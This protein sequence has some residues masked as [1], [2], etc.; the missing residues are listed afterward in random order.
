METS[1]ITLISMSSSLVLETNCVSPQPR[2]QTPF[3]PG[4]RTAAPLHLSAKD[5]EGK[6][7]CIWS[8]PGTPRAQSG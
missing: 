8:P 6:L 7:Q 3:L 1:R 2:K 4:H 5:L